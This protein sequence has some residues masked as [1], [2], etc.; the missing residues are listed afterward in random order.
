M[1][2]LNAYQSLAAKHDLPKMKVGGYE[3]ACE[4]IAT[5][6]DAWMRLAALDPRDGWLLFQSYQCSFLAGLPE[7]EPSW[8]VPLAAEAYT[9]INGA[10]VS[11]VLEQDGRGGWILTRYTHTGEGVYLLDELKQ[12]LHN[13]SKDG[14][15]K[16]KYRRYWRLDG[17]QG[18][19]QAAACFIG[20]E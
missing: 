5:P 11:I 19:L 6:A 8:G 15:G 7:R 10:T 14:P 9:E 20:F 17:R 12:L 2:I 18:Y 16:L 3:S 13:P 4:A 1:D